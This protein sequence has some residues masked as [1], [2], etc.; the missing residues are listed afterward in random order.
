M[1]H[2]RT[3]AIH[4]GNEHALLKR[5]EAEAINTTTDVCFKD[6]LCVGAVVAAVVRFKSVLHEVLDKFEIVFASLSDQYISVSHF[7]LLCRAT[8]SLEV[9][10]ARRFGC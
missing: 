2:A 9:C 10:V 6:A 3:L 1:N 4:L 8:T 5:K 7:D